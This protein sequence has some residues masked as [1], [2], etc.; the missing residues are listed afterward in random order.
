MSIFADN[1]IVCVGKLKESIKKIE[2][3]SSARLQGYMINIDV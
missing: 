3:M 2:L 1:M